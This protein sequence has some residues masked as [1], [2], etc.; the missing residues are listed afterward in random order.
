MIYVFDIDGT[1]CTNT[2][3]NYENADPFLKRIKKVN[4]LYEDGNKI[5]FMTARGMGR[6]NNDR[7][8]AYKEYYDFTYNQ[9]KS[10]GLK[11]HELYLG[12]PEADMFIDDKGEK[13]IDFF[14][15]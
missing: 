13:D 15:E 3:G 2:N 12:K 11:F 1:I 9:L 7:E 14:S 5:I 4:D 10:W 6:S 8:F